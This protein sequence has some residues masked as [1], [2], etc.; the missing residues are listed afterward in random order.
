MLLLI[1]MYFISCGSESNKSATELW[2]DG[3]KYRTEDKIKD[4]ITSYKTIIKKYP[5]D[6]FAPKAQFQIA[7]IYLNDVK[8][9]E[10]TVEEF[11]K[12]V[13]IFL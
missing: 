3:G 7:D 5:S 12:V 2:D 1:I 9:F 13:D 4:S 11:K 10:F 8:D 6:H